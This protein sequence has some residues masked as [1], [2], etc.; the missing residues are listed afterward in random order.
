MQVLAT[1]KKK[2][3]AFTVFDTFD[4]WKGKLYYMEVILEPSQINVKRTM[5][6]PIGIS[7]ENTI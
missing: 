5:S 6:F 7:Q 3:I 4:L 2:L 1:I